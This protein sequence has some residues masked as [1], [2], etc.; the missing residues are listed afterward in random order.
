MAKD[1]KNAGRQPSREA[2]RVSTGA[3]G[4]VAGFALGFG[5]AVILQVGVPASKKVDTPAT[6][7]AGNVG[8]ALTDAVDRVRQETAPAAEKAK[9]TF[10]FYNMLP[11]FE[12]VIPEQ[13]KDVRLSGNV[14]EVEQPGTYV[15]QAGSF[16]TTQDADRL[17]G[18]L[19]LI[20]LESSVQ[21][22]TIDQ[23]DGADQTWHRV[24]IGPF[25]T[26]PELN[27][28]R[29]RLAENDLQALVIR[30]GE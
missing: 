3:L 18:Q 20:G 14:N 26:L 2:S 16:R 21:T 4:L 10:D 30:V 25:A 28:A 13:D 17:R 27:D 23:S 24:R 7:G 22:V 29:R 5:A 1:Y 11:N 19:A 6:Q 9:T 8:K 12:V 15:L